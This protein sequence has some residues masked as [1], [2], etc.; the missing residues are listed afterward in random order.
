MEP[1]LAPLAVRYSKAWAD[2]DPDA[3]V[4]MHSEDTVFHE[5]GVGEPAEGRAAVRARIAELFAQTPDLAF[6]QQAVH[7]G[8]DHFVTRS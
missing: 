6:E 7:F 4:A 3:I 8:E 1:S 5:H 2:R